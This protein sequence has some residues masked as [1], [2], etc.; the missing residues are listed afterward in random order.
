MSGCGADG[1][2][3]AAAESK[4]LQVHV[5]HA[6]HDF[7][8]RHVAGSE[9][10]AME[11]ARAQ[12]A[13]HFV[14]VVCAEYDLARAHG[15]VT[16]RVHRGLPVVEIVNNWRCASFEETYRP[17]MIE[18]RLRHV[19]ETLQPDV[20]HVHNLLNL[21]FDLPAAA[22]ALG[23]PVVATLHDSTL[24]C[25]S[26]GQRVH[27]RDGHVCDAIDT[28][29]CARCFEESP[30][31]AQ[32]GVGRIAAAWPGALGLGRAVDAVKRFAPALTAP[33]VRA[34]RQLGGWT[35]R[36]EDVEA[37]LAAARQVFRE[38]DLFVSPSADLALA[39]ERFGVPADRLRVSDYGF[40]PLQ[41]PAVRRAPAHPVRLGF[42]GTLVWHK[43]VHLLIE[44]LKSLPASHFDARI[45]G[46]LQTFPDY[47]A[48]LQ[49][50]AAGLPVRFH[51]SITPE[52]IADV[53]GDIDVLVVPS[54]WPENSPL[55]IH[56]AFQS[57]IP[58]VAA[59]IGGIAELVVDG[60]SG[61]LFEPGSPADLAR[62]L[63]TLFDDPA[64]ITALSNNLPRV[65]SIAQDAA[66]WD[67]VYA[68]VTR[69][70]VRRSA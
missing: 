41:R 66:E 55:V 23:I 1:S 39:F 10:Y 12:S 51:G 68:D 32:A 19:L 25:A 52:R 21:S 44:A 28:A 56:E 58:V 54:I 2:W 34:A 13:R 65:K 69:E 27:R 26:G 61:L 4:L 35:T 24:V 50:A 62:A 36:A 38:I 60:T 46:S 9:L 57:G 7:L 20:L 43:G 8:P 37:R 3:A 31:R 5:L 14:T 70:R 40:P 64:R 47:A 29:R 59:N 16:W 30:F 67:A 45:F 42:V 17:P 11:L 63:R 6:I 33:A 15:Q 48:D 53:Y 49:A 18:K 22:K